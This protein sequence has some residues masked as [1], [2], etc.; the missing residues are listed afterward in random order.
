MLNCWLEARQ[1]GCDSEASFL[2]SVDVSI[3]SL[4]VNVICHQ[5]SLSCKCVE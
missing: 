5:V 4:A 2:A 3:A 1:E